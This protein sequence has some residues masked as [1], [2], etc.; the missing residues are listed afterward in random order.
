M[1]NLVYFFAFWL[2][3]IPSE[4]VAQRN[5][6]R[7]FFTFTTQDNPEVRTIHTYLNNGVRT[8]EAFFADSFQQT[9]EVRL[10]PH[11]GQMDSVWQVEWQMPDFHSECWMV[12]SGVG[13]KL[14]LLDPKVWPVQACEHRWEDTLASFHLLKH[15]LCHVYHGQHN[16]SPDFSQVTGLD[17]FV[18]GL[19]VYASGQCDVSRLTGVQQWLKSR[20]PLQSLDVFWTGKHKY[21]LSGSMVMYIDQTYGRQMLNQ[22]LRVQTKTALLE[23]LRCTES[24]L[25][26]A[27]YAWISQAQS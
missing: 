5:D 12:A 14:D 19:A 8:L 11:R 26:S 17:W 27:W 24:A 4:G 25:L 23:T 20:E 13:M 10:H 6:F 21:G 16:P 7:Y 18:E 1:K 2:F 22:L 3:S 15:E 9:F